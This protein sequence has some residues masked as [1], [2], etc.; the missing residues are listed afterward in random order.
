MGDRREGDRRKNKKEVAEDKRM[1][2]RRQI[3][4][5]QYLINPKFQLRWVAEVL[6]LCFGA[7]L[8]AAATCASVYI[9]VIMPED[10]GGTGLSLPLLVFMFVA[11]LAG[12]IVLFYSGILLTHRTAGPMFH[13]KRIYADI[14]KGNLSARVHLRDKDFWQDNAEAF[15]KAMDAVQER[16][17]NL[18]KAAAQ[19][20][21]NA[22]AAGA[23]GADG[24]SLKDTAE[25]VSAL[26]PR[27]D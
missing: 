14:E 15:N 8:L 27:K 25:R 9:F 11:Y 6:V 4:R 18:E 7:M 21:S 24:K 10:E 20:V 22:Q 19:L 2:E 12:F 17:T 3:K 26:I 23:E 5:R 1:D 13:F 16:Q